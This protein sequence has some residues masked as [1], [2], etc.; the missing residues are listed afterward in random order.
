MKSITLALLAFFVVLFTSCG[1]T[2]TI[3]NGLDEKDANEI[4][5]YLSSKGIPAQ[6]VPTATSGGGGGQKS[7]LWDIQVEESRSSE[8]MALLNQAGLPRRQA[9]NLLNIFQNTGLVPSELQDKIRYQAGLAEQIASTIRKIDGVLDA[10]VQISFPEEDPLNPNQKKGKITSSVYIKHNGVL[11]DPNSH[12]ISKIKRLVAASV[13]GLDY[14]N[15]TVIPDRA[16]FS[17]T[18]SGSLQTAFDAEK[19]YVN[20]WGIILAKES[21]SRFRTVFFS[22]IGLILLLILTLI[23]MSWKIMPLLEKHGGVKAFFKLHAIEPGEKGEKQKSPKADEKAAKNGE[24]T[25][26]QEAKENESSVQDKIKAGQA[27]ISSVNEPEE[28]EE[29]EEEEL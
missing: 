18:T 27:A 17:E 25:A 16:R 11:D 10:E 28:E 14:D 29:E 20:I 5:V 6:K 2:S 23:W 13:T 24:K 22:F 26:P 8:A 12:L 9:Q 1:S 19:Q 7:L 21:I 3:V 15:V 4:L